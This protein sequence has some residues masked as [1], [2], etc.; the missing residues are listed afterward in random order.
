[1]KNTITNTNSAEIINLTPHAISFVTED[2][3]HILTIEPSGALAR[4]SA[5]TEKTG[6][7]INGIP[8]TRTVYGI[9]EGLPEPKDG[10]IYLVTSIVAARCHDREDV[11]IPNESVRDEQG[12]IIGCKSLGHV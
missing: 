8:V 1:M 2:G 6:A 7:V 9:V 3:T 11:F 10:T 5:R 4:V 12:R